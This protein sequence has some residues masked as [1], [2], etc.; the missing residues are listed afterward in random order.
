MALDMSKDQIMQVQVVQAPR[1]EDIKHIFRGPDMKQEPLAVGETPKDGMLLLTFGDWCDKEATLTY[2]KAEAVQALIAERRPFNQDAPAAAARGRKL[3]ER[4][5]A[6]KSGRY[7]GTFTMDDPTLAH[8]EIRPPE[9]G[10]PEEQA[11]PELG[12]D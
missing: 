8:E 7:K 2:L 12:W 10:V 11:T 9:D 6:I 5:E 4:Y 1:P 3:R